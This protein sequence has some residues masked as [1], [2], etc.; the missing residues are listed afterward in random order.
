ML[1]EQSWILN[2]TSLTPCNIALIDIPSKRKWSYEQLSKE[3]LKWWAFLKNR[4][5]NK[6]D[7]IALLAEN[8]ID[9]FP[10]LFACGL[11]GYIYVPLNW[12]LSSAELSVILDDCQPSILITDERFHSLGREIFGKQPFKIVDNLQPA[13]I[14][15]EKTNEWSAE[16][17][18]LMIYTGGT[19]GKPK[20]VLLSFEAVNWNAIN[21]AISW[22]LNEEDCT[23]NYMPLFHTGG[24]NALSLPILMMGGTVVIG[25]Q[26]HAEEA[27][28]AVNDYQTTISLFVP[29]MYQSMIETDYFK[30]AS[31]PSVKVFLSGGAPCP[32]T[33]YR[34]FIEKGLKFKEGYG[35]TEAGPNNFYISPENAAKKVGSVGKNMLFN[36]I[37]LINQHGKECEAEE[38]GELYIKGKHVFTKYWNNP[39]ETKKA[40]QDGWLKTGDLAKQD[41]DGDFYI[42]GRTKDMIITGGEN[43]YPLEVEQCIISHPSVKEVAVV[44]LKDEKWGEVVAAFIVSHENTGNI[45]SEIQNLCREQLGSYKVP[46]KLFFVEELPKTPV[47]KIDKK[48]LVETFV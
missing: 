20:G 10:I 26:F 40:I 48:Q 17:P 39:E 9:I 7:R 13:P 32:K 16:D 33:I 6:G 28:R 8:C 23:L 21:T 2:R 34:H 43:V 45:K 31:F 47:G 19:T 27:I 35:L 4:G 12:R 36:T 5:L 38:V 24:L 25:N 14:E 15:F 18:W 37:K 46:K 41:Q 11:G 3:C 30:N 29:T 44:G 1:N 22:N 42:V